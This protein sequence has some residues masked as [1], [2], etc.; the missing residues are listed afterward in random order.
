MGGERVIYDFQDRLKFSQGARCST[1]TETILR[2][3]DGCASV[4]ENVTEGNDNGIDYIAK[5]RRGAAVYIDAKTREKG[6]S[7][8]WRGGKPELAIELWSVMPGGKYNTPKERARTGW[9]LDESKVTDM[10]LYTFAPADCPTA[11]LLPFQSLRIAARRGVK[12]WMRKYKTDIQTSGGWQSQ[13]VFVPAEV[14]VAAVC[15]TFAAQ[16]K[17]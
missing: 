4:T 11:F 2:L 16:I 12:E 17:T 13:A 9:T 5:L 10:I 7:K 3:L 6:C 14:V 8:Y 15:D 1:D